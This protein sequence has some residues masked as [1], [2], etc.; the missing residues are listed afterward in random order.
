MLVNNSV[1]VMLCHSANCMNVQYYTPTSTENCLKMK[2]KLSM[3]KEKHFIASNYITGYDVSKDF[4]LE[5][6]G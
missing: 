4:F 3:K 6:L 5:V 2:L 1:F